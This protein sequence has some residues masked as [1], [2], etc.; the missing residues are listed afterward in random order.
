MKS[1]ICRRSLVVV[2]FAVS[3]LAWGAAAPARQLVVPEQLPTA[4]RTLAPSFVVASGATAVKI[5]FFDADST[6]RVAPSGNVCPNFASDV[7]VLPKVGEK[8]GALNAEGYLVAIVSNQLGVSKGYITA[9]AADGALRE[10]CRQ[11]AANGGIVHWYDYAENRD[12]FRK[13]EI[14]MAE[15]V[16]SAVT[17]QLHLPVDW[18]NSFMVGDSGYKKGEAVEP[19]G[20][21]GEDISSDDRLFAEN[22]AKAHA[23]FAYKHAR[24]FFG[25]VQYGVRN[26]HKYSE[27][28]AFLQKNPGVKPAGR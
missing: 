4:C 9:A 3:L 20:T 28:E 24:D 13:P 17:A 23:G 11:I 15:R 26:F 25:W 2:V 12:A 8:I 21:P 18:A 10:T 1:C 5:A 14:G 27:L 22:V 7:A 6:L 16:A 19:D